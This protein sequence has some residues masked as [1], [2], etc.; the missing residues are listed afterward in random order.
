MKKIGQIILGL[1]TAASVSVVEAQTPA[2]PGA[3]GFGMYTTGGRGG[4]VYHVT[5]LADDGSAG[6]LRHAVSQKGARTIVFDVSGTIELTKALSI[7]N[8][9]LT[10]AGQ[11]APGDGICLKNYELYLNAR[12]VIIRFMRF[13]LGDQKPDYDANGNPSLDRDAA[14]GRRKGDIIIDHCSM[15]WCTDECASFYDN[16]NFTMQWCMI[17]ESLRGSLHPK[18]YHG[19]GGIWGGQGASFHHNMLAHHDSRNPRLCGSRYSNAPDLELVD[20]RNNVIYN[21]GATNSGYA[22]EGGNYNFVNNY[23]KS[24]PATGSNI[25]YRI[26]S[27]NADDGSNSQ[28]QG[29]YG[30][31]YVSGNYMSEKGENWDWSGIDVDN[32][33]N[34]S[35]TKEAIKSYTM[36]PVQT[37]T[38]HSAEKAFEKVCKLAG[39]SLSRDAVDSHVAQDAIQG[40]YTYTGSVLGGKGIIDKVSDVGGWPELKSLP[41]PI[42]SDGDGMPDEWEESHGL[43]KNDASDGAVLAS[44]GSGYTNLE[45][46]M[47][48]IVCEIMAEGLADAL[49]PSDYTC[50]EAAPDSAKL[51]KHGAGSSSQS[52]NVGEN[53]APFSFSW[54]YATSVEVSGLP[55]GIVANIDNNALSVSFSGAVSEDVESGEYAYTVK[56]VG[57]INEAVKGG[58]FKVANPNDSINSALNNV[59]AE[60]VNYIRVVRTEPLEL[61]L[62]LP[63]ASIVSIEVYDINGRLCWKDISM[64]DAGKSVI[65]VP[66]MTEKVFTLRY[67]V[68][69]AGSNTLKA[70]QR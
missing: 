6:T 12:N 59:E 70:I 34:S 36:F 32:R 54:L 22:G 66:Q 9:D 28:P 67:S 65:V 55:S 50:D 10:I 27:P 17:A 60:D 1:A 43:D 44:G 15:S 24:G 52:I 21:W 26:F 58:V 69:S 4:K 51:V 33:N 5:S 7:S 63:N 39:A 11:T 35:M 30:H 23:Y 41:A 42:D 64:R 49:T 8:G 47:N 57:G 53:I 18:G 19:Y 25:K 31:F 62:N 2:F 46:Y 56:T 14:W 37:V 38:T 48:S 61:E 68:A 3:E 16:S 20:V 13:R 45:V 40:K 29:V